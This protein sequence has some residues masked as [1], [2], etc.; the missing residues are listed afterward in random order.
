MRTN[1]WLMEISLKEADDQLNRVS[2]AVSSNIRTLRKECGIT[3]QDLAV[4]VHMDKS[5]ISDIENCR[6][7]NLTMYT[8][9][10]LS[11]YFDVKISDLLREW[12]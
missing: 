12:K 3:Q 11:I 1:Q 2:A 9:T 10:K 8:L 4:G 5:R 7:G 6:A